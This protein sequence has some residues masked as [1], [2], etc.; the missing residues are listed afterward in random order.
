MFLLAQPWT[1]MD[2]ILMILYAVI[3]INFRRKKLYNEFR[4]ESN[5]SKSILEELRRMA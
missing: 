3:F 4:I 2:W 5:Q 1:T